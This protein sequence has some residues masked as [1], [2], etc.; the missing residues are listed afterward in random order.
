MNGSQIESSGPRARGARRRP[1]P[2]GFTM[3]EVLIAGVIIIIGFLGI[4]AL[5]FASLAANMRAYEISTA[6]S[7]AETWIETL[8]RESLMWNRT[9]PSP[10]DLPDA[11]LMPNLSN[12]LASPA[13]GATNG[14]VAALPHSTG[15]VFNRDGDLAS[16]GTPGHMF[17]VHQRLTWL[18]SVGMAGVFAPETLRVEVRVLWPRESRAGLGAYSNCGAGGGADAM[19]ADIANVV[20]IT[21][22][23]VIRRYASSGV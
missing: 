14:W 20:S 16:S 6:T 5:Q 19:A 11:A 21:V 8:R 3:I 13:A 12:G 9:T 15:L 22:P 23:T 17:C 7:L 18:N 2:R 1:G 4:F 10:V